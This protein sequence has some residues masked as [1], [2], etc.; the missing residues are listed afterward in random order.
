MSDHEKEPGAAP[1]NGKSRQELGSVLS[2]F[3]LTMIP[4]VGTVY[5]LHV[6]EYLGIAVYQ[7]QYLSVLLTLMLVSTFLSVPSKKGSLKRQI[8]WYD[9]VLVLLS[10][11]G[12]GYVAVYYPDIIPTLGYMVPF[13]TVMGGMMILLILEAARRLVGWP[14]VIIGILFPIYAATSYFLPGFLHSRMIPVGRILSYIYLSPGAMMG[15]PLTVAGTIVFSFIFFGRVLFSTG[16]G[17]FLSDFALALMGRYRGGPA[18]VAI[19]ASCFFGSLSGSASANVAMTGIVTIPLMKRTGYKPHIAAAIEAVASTGGLIMPPIMAATAFIM[20][21]FMEIPYS[22]IAVS[23]FIPALLYYIA[24]FIQVHLQAVKDDL[25]GLPRE[26][27]PSL[28]EVMKQGWIYLI[29]TLVLLYCLFAL[30]MAPETSALYAVAA[31]V[32]VC[33]FKKDTR[34]VV[35]GQA[36]R[37][38]RDTGRGVLEVGIICGIAGIVIGSMDLTGIGLSLSDALV[39]LSGGNAMVLLVL[40]AIGAI[41]LGMGMPVT[42]TYIMLVVLIAP[43]LIELGIEPLAAHLF[44][45][46]FGVMSFLTPPVAIAAYVAASIAKSEP[47]RTGF[48]GVRLGIVAYIVPFVFAL[49]PS[50]I[51][52]GSWDEILLTTIT[53]LLGIVFLSIAFEGYL[54]ARLHAGKRILFAV[55]ALFLIA[56]SLK[57]CIIGLAL[58]V[59][60]VLWELRRKKTAPSESSPQGSRGYP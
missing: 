60:L 45:M 6:P 57:G 43:A 53:A 8:H 24:V 19:L 28:K 7:E 21:E 23:A 25:K 47:M 12:G 49:S 35:I 15:I 18:K 22:T 44:I 42:A 36:W 9:V 51:L 41:I 32:I 20:A 5:V 37:I 2:K 4:L 46:Y 48:A 39:S 40:A 34:R 29:P 52:I 50:L 3:T 55:G 58:T 17:K 30:Y 11:V 10:L 33:L 38:L 59:P 27:L 14:I 1:G 31:T 13:R 16:G 54:F 56:P 26:E